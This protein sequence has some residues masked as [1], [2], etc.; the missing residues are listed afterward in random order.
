MN[1]S[2]KTELIYAA[3]EDWNNI[4]PFLIREFLW[5]KQKGRS[6][7]NLSEEIKVY[8]KLGQLPQSELEKYLTSSAVNGSENNENP[9]SIQDKTLVP[10][11]KL[12]QEEKADFQKK[13]G[14]KTEGLSPVIKEYI[15]SG[16]W[17]KNS[18][19]LAEVIS[20]APSAVTKKEEK[21]TVKL[22]LEKLSEAERTEIKKLAASGGANVNALTPL[23]IKEYLWRKK[24]KKATKNLAAEVSSFEKLATIPQRQLEKLLTSTAVNGSVK[25]VSLPAA[26]TPVVKLTAEEK[27]HFHQTYGL[28]TEGLSPVVQTY[29]KSGT[30][31]NNKLTNDSLSLEAPLSEATLSSHTQELPHSTIQTH[32]S[33]EINA[34]DVAQLSPEPLSAPLKESLTHLAEY[35]HTKKQATQEMTKLDRIN[36]NYE[37][38]KAVLAKSEPLFA[39]NQFWDVGHAEASG[40]LTERDIEKVSQIQ[41]DEILQKIKGM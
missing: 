1:E 27:Q 23:F 21:K 41:S 22:L 28:P 40:E 12:T 3:G 17:K 31:K 34:N 24:N 19:V 26:G 6:V 11:T 9:A 4:T 14:I 8:E 16:E 29:I 32:S 36:A 33:R 25:K 15:K 5:R 7:K 10:V 13:Y 39:K 35:R 18:D 2:E 30:W 20:G 38:D 37:H